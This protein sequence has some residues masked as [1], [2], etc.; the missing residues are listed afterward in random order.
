MLDPISASGEHLDIAAEQLPMSRHFQ[1]ST[2]GSLVQIVDTPSKISEVKTESPRPAEIL[3]GIRVEDGGKLSSLDIAVWEMVLTWTYEIDPKM[4]GRSYSI[5][6]SSLRRFLGEFVKR[7]EVVASF[8]KLRT[9]QLSFGDEKSRLYSGVQMIVPWQ[10]SDATTGDD[11]FSYS[12]AEPF[13][14][15]MRSMREYAHIELAPLCS[16]NKHEM[17]LYKFLALTAA[18]R[19]W[20]PGEENR[21]S[22]EITPDEL[23]D[24]LDFP[25]DQNGKYNIGKLSAVVAGHPADYEKVRRF[26]V[27]NA[28]PKYGSVRGRKVSHYEIEI[29]ICPPG[30][31]HAS[32]RYTPGEFPRGGRDDPKYQIRSDHWLRAVRTFRDTATFG[33]YTHKQYF[34]LWLVALSEALNEEPLTL[35]YHRGSSR[36]SSLLQT[37]E[38]E[39]AAAAAWALFIDEADDSDLVEYIADQDSVSKGHLNR[40]SDFDRRDR[41]GWNTARKRDAA[42]HYLHKHK[43]TD[44]EDIYVAETEIQKPKEADEFR[45]Y[46]GESD[47]PVPTSDPRSTNFDDATEIQ[48]TFKRM[49]LDVLEETVFPILISGAG[50]GKEVLVVSAYQDQETGETGFYEKKIEV[51]FDEWAAMLHSLEPHMLMMEEYING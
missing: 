41:I 2:R 22:I 36:G 35:G 29:Q 47:D 3:K 40:M 33:A 20:Q 5:P 30:W 50:G 16:M 12:F 28:E 43:R 23:A 27:I 39:G 49:P 15:V 13:R 19:K 48:L 38:Q 18:K 4:S 32:A 14:I 11:F 8:N 42:K 45:Y 21:F 34:E 7:K 24:I 31:Q 6:A 37:I 17:A 25:R 9:V 51:T 46:F 44:D 26:K 10:E 1:P